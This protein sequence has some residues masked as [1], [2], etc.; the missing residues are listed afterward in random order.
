M[1]H[2]HAFLCRTP[3]LSL[4]QKA[5]GPQRHEKHPGFGPSNRLRKPRC[6]KRRIVVNRDPFR[7]PRF[8]EALELRSS[9]HIDSSTFPAVDGW[10]STP[11]LPQQV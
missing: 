6:P 9:R 7:H 2:P 8:R 4:R 11:L 10:L 3:P 5:C 1:F